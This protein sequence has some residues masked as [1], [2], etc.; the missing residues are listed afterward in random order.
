MLGRDSWKGLCA[1]VE[2]ANPTRRT[3][4]VHSSMLI[5]QLFKPS[6]TCTY[7]QEVAV[8]LSKLRRTVFCFMS[9]HDRSLILSEAG[10]CWR[11]SRNAGLQ[12]SSMATKRAAS[13]TL[14]VE[15]LK[16]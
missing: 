7:S 8:V 16:C 9:T 3:Y 2:R 1:E 14:N 15:T 4:G 5:T 13:K 12:A 11:A 10:I 6:T